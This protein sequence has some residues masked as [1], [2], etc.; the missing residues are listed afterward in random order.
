[1]LAIFGGVGVG[2]TQIATTIVAKHLQVEEHAVVT[3]HRPSELVGAIAR[4]ED[5]IADVL[6]VDGLT[7]A[8]IK[9]PHLTEYLIERYN[10]LESTILVFDLPGDRMSEVPLQIRSMIQETGAIINCVW[11]SL[12][13]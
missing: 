3:Y 5:I 13:G 7:A 12:R 9:N 4:G 6:V 10:D 1:M 2:K 8:D 11:P